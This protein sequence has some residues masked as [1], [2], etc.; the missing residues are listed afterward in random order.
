MSCGEAEGGQIWKI[1]LAGHLNFVI[2]SFFLVCF[3][4]KEVTVLCPLSSCGLTKAVPLNLA[5]GSLMMSP[6]VFCVFP[7]CFYHCFCGKV[8]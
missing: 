1:F 7:V 5:D 6:E 3:G 4:I 8:W 2:V